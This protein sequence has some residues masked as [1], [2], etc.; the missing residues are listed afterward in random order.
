MQ[1]TTFHDL[2][3]EYSDDVYRFSYWLTGNSHDAADITSETFVRAWTSSDGAK[4][5]SVKAYLFAIAR[6]LVRRQSRRSSR[7]EALEK[8]TQDKS[9]DP[10]ASAESRDELRRVHE[11]VQSL[12]ELDRVLFSLRAEQELSY[13]DI[14]RITGLS[15][16]AAKVRV[17]R[18]RLKITQILEPDGGKLT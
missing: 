15:V 4:M 5:D 1:V 11:I 6:N 13:S 18:M 16:A 8:E 17:F 9:I 2:Y 12:P 7:V 10:S 14:A 3:A